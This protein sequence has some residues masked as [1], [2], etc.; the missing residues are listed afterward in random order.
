MGDREVE[1]PRRAEQCMLEHAARAEAALA[2]TLIDNGASRAA[3]GVATF[4]GGGGARREK[5]ATER[6]FRGGF[7][8]VLPRTDDPS[9]LTCIYGISRF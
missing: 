6:N 3:R 7:R 2:G 5:Y 4:R 1:F 8:L 9:L